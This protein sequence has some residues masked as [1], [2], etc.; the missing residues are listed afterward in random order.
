MKTVVQRVD[1]AKLS[2]SGREVVSIGQGLVVYLGFGL[3]DDGA[4]I[5]ALCKKLA[6]LRIFSDS[7]GKMNLSVRDVGGAILLIPN[8]TLCADAS[9]GNRPSFSTALEPVAAERLFDE[10]A[11]MLGALVPTVTGVFGADMV[12]EQ[13]NN[14]PINI[15]Y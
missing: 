2:I 8:F 12:I 11:S 4:G 6:A 10:C 1:C 9:H 7:A 14:G 5:P 13:V 3:G 15:L